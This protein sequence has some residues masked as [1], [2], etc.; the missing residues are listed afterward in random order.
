MVA[1]GPED[2]IGGVPG[3]EGSFGTTSLRFCPSCLAF[4]SKLV[5]EKEGHP[6][7]SSLSM[8]SFY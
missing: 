6:P 4:C 1:A 2:A 3:E 8:P 7:A 5:L